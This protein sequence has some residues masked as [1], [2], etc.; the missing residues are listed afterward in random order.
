MGGNEGESSLGFPDHAIDD[1]QQDGPGGGDD[2]ATE[3]ER[4]D[5]PETDEG[6]EKAADDS[7]DDP[8]EDGD[9]NTARV[10]ARHDELGKQRCRI[11]TKPSRGR[12][13]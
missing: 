12:E 7:A 1:E 11:R 6:S 10:L 8:D 4:S 13:Y 5:F 2:D 9:E 3:I